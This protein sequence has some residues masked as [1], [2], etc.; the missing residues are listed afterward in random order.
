MADAEM[1]RNARIAAEEAAKRREG[2]LAEAQARAEEMEERARQAESR[3]TGATAALEVS[4][5]VCG[6]TT[7]ELS[8]IH[9]RERR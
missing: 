6:L 1:Q 2:A 5:R 7:L 8:A 3:L 9:V 4:A